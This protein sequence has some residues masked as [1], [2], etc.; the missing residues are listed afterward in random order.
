MNQPCKQSNT[1]LACARPPEGAQPIQPQSETERQLNEMGAT[2]KRVDALASQIYSRLNR[3]LRPTMAG[4]IGETQA[5]E[6]ILCPL[7]SEI[8]EKTNNLMCVENNL[9]ELL[10]R[11]EL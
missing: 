8:R 5:P 6:V 11:I 2:I 1:P 4:S 9:A 7:A 10:S 3:A